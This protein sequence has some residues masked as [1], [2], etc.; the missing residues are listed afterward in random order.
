MLS[1][2]YNKPN[3]ILEKQRIYQNDHRNVIRRLPRSG[4]Y[5]NLFGI[6]FVA[7]MIGTTYGV[8]SLI[9]G[10]STE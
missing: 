2:L 7:G 6:G 1:A 3:A 4:L 8:V 10:K 5:L 9:K